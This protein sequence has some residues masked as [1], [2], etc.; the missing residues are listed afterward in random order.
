LSCISAS[1]PPSSCG[2]NSLYTAW[3]DCLTANGC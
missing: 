2:S 3:S 1:S